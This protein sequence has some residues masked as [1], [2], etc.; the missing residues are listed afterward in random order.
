M[1]RPATVCRPCSP[2]H[3]VGRALPCRRGGQ[4][5]PTRRIDSS[6]ARAQRI[7]GCF[8]NL[9]RLAMQSGGIGRQDLA[10]RHL[11]GFGAVAQQVDRQRQSIV[12]VQAGILN[13]RRRS[14]RNAC[15][16]RPPRPQ[17][18]RLWRRRRLF[19]GSANVPT[20]EALHEAPTRRRPYSGKRFF[21]CFRIQGRVNGRRS[22]TE[23]PERAPPSFNG[24]GA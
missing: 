4:G 16:W 8:Q 10:G 2:P 1:S 24:C 12:M 17:R 11:S 13:P 15:F 23:G 22:R 5:L 19:G 9:R 21:F 7:A 3:R 14:N 20:P 18:T 6:Q